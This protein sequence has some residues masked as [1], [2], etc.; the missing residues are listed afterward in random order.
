MADK[1][2]KNTA[3]PAADAFGGALQD[4][5]KKIDKRNEAIRKLN[6]SIQ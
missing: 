5:I 3:R 2:K 4:T 1:K 6:K